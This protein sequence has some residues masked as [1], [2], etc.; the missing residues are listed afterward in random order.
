MYKEIMKPLFELS[1][2]NFEKEINLVKNALAELESQCE[3]TN[4]YTIGP[5]KTIAGWAFFNIELSLEMFLIIETSGMMEG[6]GGYR[7]G[8]QITSFMGHF[9]EL[10]GSQ[11]RIKKI[12]Y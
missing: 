12:S 3:V 10:H 11:V 7:I 2:R 1:T 9:L 4:G 6:A 8:E 5:P